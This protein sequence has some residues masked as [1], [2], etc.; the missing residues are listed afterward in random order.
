LGQDK[1]KKALHLYFKR[2]QWKNTEL[3]DFV[4]VLNEVYE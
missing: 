1:L 2:Y 3:K 4:G